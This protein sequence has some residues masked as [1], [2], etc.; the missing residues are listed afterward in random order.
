MGRWTQAAHDAGQLPGRRFARVFPDPYTELSDFTG[1]IHEMNYILKVLNGEM[2]MEEYP[3]QKDEVMNV[4]AIIEAFY[5]SAQL[6][7]KSLLR[8][9]TGKRKLQ[10]I[11]A[12]STA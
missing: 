6:A 11:F 5:K 3:I 1:H 4:V 10:G 9:W 2:T 7:G 12:Q 8:N